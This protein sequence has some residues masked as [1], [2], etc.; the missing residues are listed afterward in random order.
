MA[1]PY[2]VSVMMKGYQIVAQ[3]WKDTAERYKEI[4]GN[5]RYDYDEVKDLEARLNAYY[6]ILK[7]LG[8][9]IVEA[10]L[11]TIEGRP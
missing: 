5:D 3:I 2:D 6:E 9:T 1:S 7:E 8:K 10:L 4:S 11:P